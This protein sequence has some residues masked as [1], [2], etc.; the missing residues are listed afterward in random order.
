MKRILSIIL[1][2]ILLFG[3]VACGKK[4][5]KNTA[6][7]ADKYCTACGNGVSLA[8]AFC[9]KCGNAFNNTADNSTDTMSTDISSTD[10][11]SNDTSSNDTP[12]SGSQ[13]TESVIH[14]HSYTKTDKAATC[15]KGGYSE[16]TCSCGHSYKDSYTDALGHTYQK[17]VTDPTC[18]TEGKTTYT[19]WCKSTYSE[20][21]AK[22][23][24]KYENFKCKYCN[25]PVKGKEF[26]VLKN[27][28]IEN[29]DKY[30]GSHYIAGTNFI[31]GDGMILY[32]PKA[33]IIAISNDYIAS[34]LL[35]IYIER[36]SSK[37]YVNYE[38]SYSDDLIM[39]TYSGTFD[40]GTILSN[41]DISSFN[42]Y[43]DLIYSVTQE[44]YK[45]RFFEQFERTLASTNVF[46]SG[47]FGNLPDTH[48]TVADFGFVIPQ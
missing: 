27:W 42:F 6:Q 37:Y 43:T 22:V 18:E 34:E 14:T 1:V 36:N 4:T 23:D 3:A 46:L 28:I 29:G 13:V 39:A 48:L 5:E 2:L 47:N 35:S 17:S 9:P 19:C 38:Y 11:S 24:H 30:D 31:Y 12:S 32:E 40:P 21:I 10:A 41:K 33:D 8:D 25:L 26:D 16:Y 45:D 15:T 44:T 7:K 20:A